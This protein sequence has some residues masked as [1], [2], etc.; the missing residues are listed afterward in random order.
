MPIDMDEFDPEL[1]RARGARRSP[2]RPN[3]HL[4]LGRRS[5]SAPNSTLGGRSAWRWFPM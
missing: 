3:H 2:R 1:L 4:R 5:R